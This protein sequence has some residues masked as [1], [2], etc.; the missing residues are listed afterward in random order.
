VV[1]VDSSVW[2]AHLQ[3]GESR[4]ASLLATQQVL[5]HEM[6]L[7]EV[8]M[9]SQKQREQALLLLP[10]LPL[11]PVATHQE[12]MALVDKHRLYARG[13]GYVDVHLLTS[14]A[15]QPGTQLWSHDKRLAAAADQL[16]LAFSGALH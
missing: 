13:I 7:G 15:L 12:V 11:A 10:F 16:G 8:A 1:L 14:A 6:I 4:L 2:I 3:S 5:M 9:G